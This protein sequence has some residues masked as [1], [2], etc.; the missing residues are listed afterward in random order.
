MIRVT[1]ICALLMVLSIAIVAQVGPDFGRLADPSD[2][3]S[4]TF[5]QYEKAPL[6]FSSTTAYILVPVVVTDKDGN[7]VHGLTKE[8]FRVLENGKEQAIASL[9]EFKPTGVALPRAT[10]APNEFTNQTSES[11]DGVAARRLVIIVL[12]M[13]NMEFP[14]QSRARRALIDYVHDNVESGTL[15]QLVSLEGDGMHVLHDFTSNTSALIS[16]LDKVKNRI[17]LGGKV[18]KAAIGHL[19]TDPGVRSIPEQRYPDSALPDFEATNLKLFAE[20]ERG[21]AQ[22]VNAKLASETLNA[23]QHLAAR[24]SGVPGR[25]SLVW[26]TGAFPFSLDPRTAA[27]GEGVSFATYQ[28]VMTQLTDQM[29]SIYPVDARGVLTLGPDASWKLPVREDTRAMARAQSDSDRQ[30]DI[31]ETMRA[32]ADL[33]GGHA[34]VNTNDTRGAIKEAGR[35][36]ASYYLLSYPMNKSDKRAGYRKITVKV[37]DYKIRARNGYFATQAAIDA[38]VSA[39]NDLDTALNSPLDY[40]G[41]PLRL[42]L[43]KPEAAGAKR[44]LTFSMVMPPKAAKIDA[45]DGNHLFVEIA[46]A[47][48]SSTGQDAGHKG[49]TYNLKLQPMQLDAFNTQ[50]IGYGDTIEVAPGSYTLRVVVRDNLTGKLGSVLA[51]VEVN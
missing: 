17:S 43:D 11:S 4:I 41:L 3:Y 27:V 42:V 14:D 28:H 30:R 44:K 31:L 32:F 33:T 10:T 45:E 23:F 34:Y 29:I 9:E 21:Y 51:P 7:P 46:Y 37:G 1:S 47:L 36:G 6:K 20:A 22:I 25:K 8:Q 12:D 49:V 26:I 50:G 19:G 13:L 38:L 5:Q 16:A 15:Y 24:V 48:K 35:D 39:K 40:T 18:D 2:Q